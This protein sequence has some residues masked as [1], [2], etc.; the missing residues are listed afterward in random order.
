MLQTR[1][2]PRCNILELRKST[3]IDQIINEGHSTTTRAIIADQTV[4][5]QLLMKSAPG[6][7]GELVRRLHLPHTNPERLHVLEPYFVI[8]VAQKADLLWR[9][10]ISPPLLLRFSIQNESEHK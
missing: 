3:G 10:S 6:N 1:L 9:L 8:L 7:F 4:I 5:A 2:Y